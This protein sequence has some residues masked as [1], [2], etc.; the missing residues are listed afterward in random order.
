MPPLRA[1][2]PR[3]RGAGRN[4]RRDDVADSV[5]LGRP[6]SVKLTSAASLSGLAVTL[7]AIAIFEVP[8]A[9]SCCS[10]NSPID[11]DG[12]DPSISVRSE[13]IELNPI[14]PS[15]CEVAAVKD[16]LRIRM[17]A[18]LL[19]GRGRL[20]GGEGVYIIVRIVCS[21]DN[22]SRNTGGE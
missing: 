11:V 21:D 18:A 20:E 2:V 7:P 19:G 9:A 8:S 22:V 16:V 10:A 6:S 5:L 1:M 17:C 3:A 12:P 13:S 14:A 4:A 15:G